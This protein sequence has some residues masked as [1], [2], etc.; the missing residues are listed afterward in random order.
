V[1]YTPKRNIAGQGYLKVTSIKTTHNINDI[2]GFNLSNVPVLWN[3]PANP[4]WSEQFNTI[5]NAALVDTQRIGRPGNVSEIAGVNTSCVSDQTRKEFNNI[6]DFMNRGASLDGNILRMKTAD[7][8][9]KRQQDLRTVEPEFA[10]IIE[11]TG[12]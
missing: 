2:N 8:D 6:I 9:R 7:L 1:S 3:D 12:P 5:I 10:S 4:N 11:Y